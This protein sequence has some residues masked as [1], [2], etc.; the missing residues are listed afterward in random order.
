MSACFPRHCPRDM[1]NRLRGPLKTLHTLESRRKISQLCPISAVKLVSF[2][3]GIWVK[4]MI[5]TYAKNVLASC[6][7]GHAKISKISKAGRGTWSKDTD[8]DASCVNG[9]A[10][11]FQIVKADRGTWSKDTNKAYGLNIAIGSS[12]PVLLQD[13]LTKG[14]SQSSTYT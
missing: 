12:L 1:T 3:F 9:N 13:Q 7:N 2:S 6:I 5:E 8:I 10:K 4:F 11:I 14:T